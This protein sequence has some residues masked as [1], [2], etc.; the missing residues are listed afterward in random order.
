MENNRL[1]EFID[2]VIPKPPTSD[3]KD[4]AELRKCV[5]KA[6]RIILEGIRDHIVLNL[7]SKETPFAMWKAS[8]YLFQNNSD[9][10]KMAM[11]KKLKNINIEKGDSIPNYMTKFTQCQDELGSV[12]VTIAEGDLVSL[13]L[14]GLPKS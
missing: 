4:L 9:H 3:A 14:L 6:R 7:H 10:K 11:K 2:R 5:V 8:T 1:K 13:E 12:S